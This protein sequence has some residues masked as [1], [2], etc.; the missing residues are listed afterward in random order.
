MTL[1]WTEFTTPSVVSLGFTEVSAPLS[2]VMLVFAEVI[3]ALFF[4]YIVFQQAGIILDAR[5]IAKEGEVQRELA[6][7]A[8]LALHRTADAAGGRTALA[9][10]RHSGFCTAHEGRRA[11]THA[12]TAGQSEVAL[13]FRTPWPAATV[14]LRRCHGDAF[15]Q[16][17][18]SFDAGGYIILADNPRFAGHAV[19]TLM[20]GAAL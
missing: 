1:N 5:P 3:N 9:A 12:R 11:A 17:A 8:E 15:A 20:R 16:E 2:V 10:E 4:V 18:T 7:K 6:D 19:I 13:I 14:L